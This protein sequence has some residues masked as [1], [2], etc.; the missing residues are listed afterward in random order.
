[1]PNAVAVGAQGNLFI[2][3]DGIIRRVDAVTGIIVTV[4]GGPLNPLG[5]GDGGPATSASI[6]ALGGV[7]VDTQ[8]RLLI[9]DPNDNRIR[10]VP[11]PPFVALSPA[12]LSFSAQPVGTASATQTITLTNTGLVPLSIS[13]IAIAGTNAADYAE[14]STCAGSLGAGANCTIGV[15]FT[16]AAAGSRTATLTITD[17]AAGSPQS[18]TLNGTTQGADFS[19]TAAS[20]SS[21][22]ATVTPGQTATYNLIVTPQGGL[23][24]VVAFTCNGAPSEATCTVSPTSVNLSGSG[25]APITVTVSTTAQSG[26]RGLR[27]P[28]KG[29]WVLTWLL[30]ILSGLA[31]TVTWWHRVARRRAW[32]PLVVMMVALAPGAG[33]GGGGNTGGSGGNSGTPAGTYTLTVSGSMASGTTTLQ[34][35]VTLTL[36]VN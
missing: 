4:A 31:W 25:S 33:C 36:T 6:F 13:S 12:A 10:V 22:S 28:P 20:G 14:S 32:V 18:I 23:T 21:T 3:C 15:I 1:M 7:A 2:A 30:A 11:L 17:S 9:A 19:L 24:G 27:E 5:I 34:H 26:I 29:P 16:P 8:G 35:N